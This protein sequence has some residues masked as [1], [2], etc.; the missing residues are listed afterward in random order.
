MQIREPGAF[1]HW[2]GIPGPELHCLQLRQPCWLKSEE[3]YQWLVSPK[4]EGRTINYGGRRHKQHNPVAQL[5]TDTAWISQITTRVMAILTALST[6]RSSAFKWC[7]HLRGT[8]DFSFLR[9]KKNNVLVTL[10]LYSVHTHVCVTQTLTDGSLEIR[11]HVQELVLSF[12][13]SQGNELGPSGLVGGP[14]PLWVTSLAPFL[15]S[16]RSKLI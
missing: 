10:Y 12:H 2:G 4:N 7:R 6:C 9:F 16:R 14:L 5:W 11:W 1:G 15:Q 8:Q 13:H 3:L